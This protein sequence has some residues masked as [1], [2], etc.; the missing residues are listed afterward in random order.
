M[1]GRVSHLL[2]NTNSQAAPCRQAIARSLPGGQKKGRLGDSTG[3]AVAGQDG[4]AASTHKGVG[5]AGTNQVKGEGPT[6]ASFAQVTESPNFFLIRKPVVFPPPRE[7]DGL[8]LVERG[9]SEAT[10]STKPPIASPQGWNHMPETIRQSIGFESGQWCS[11]KRG[12]PA[13]FVIWQA[14]CVRCILFTLGSFSH[15]P[16]SILALVKMG[17]GCPWHSLDYGRGGH[18][19]HESR[20][21][22][23]VNSHHYKPAIHAFNRYGIVH[24][25][26]IARFCHGPSFPQVESDCYPCEFQTTPLPESGLEELPATALPFKLVSGT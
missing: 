23:C 14:D 15:D 4:G 20:L 8:D 25:W 13:A 22:F 17:K 24:S 21:C 5:E 10:P 7:N 19:L 11:L 9:G 16:S 26:D 3:N 2:R 18:S 1:A 6:P 12:R